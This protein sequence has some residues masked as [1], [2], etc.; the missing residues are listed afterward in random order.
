MSGTLHHTNF[1]IEAIRPPGKQGKPEEKRRFWQR[2]AIIDLI[3]PY[4]A[5]D[6]KGA[7]WYNGCMKFPLPG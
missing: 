3:T 7:R 5:G 4:L 2:S 1:F 6:G